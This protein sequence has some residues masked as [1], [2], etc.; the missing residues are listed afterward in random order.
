MQH[1]D[2]V[3]RDR[4]DELNVFAGVLVP[5]TTAEGID[6][7]TGLWG[8]RYGLI[9]SDEQREFGTK[10]SLDVNAS[11]APAPVGSAHRPR[12]SWFA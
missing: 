4:S 7:R 8:A 6:R 11:V 1:D 3:L 10:R 12:V 2:V 5:H 9:S